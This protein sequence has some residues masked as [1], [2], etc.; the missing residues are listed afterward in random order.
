MYRSI[1]QSLFSIVAVNVILIFSCTNASN[2]NET[3][4]ETTVVIQNNEESKESIASDSP[5]NNAVKLKTLPKL[6]AIVIKETMN[7]VEKWQLW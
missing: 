7:L 4:A 5:L 6:S 3:P 2:N 1:I